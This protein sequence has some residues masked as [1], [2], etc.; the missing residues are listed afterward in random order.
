[1]WQ[2][3]T[4]RFLIVAV[5][6]FGSSRSASAQFGQSQ[7]DRLPFDDRDDE[8]DDDEEDDEDEDDDDDEDVEED[9]DE[10]EFDLA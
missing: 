6:A 5:L 1:M 8:D 2:L 10:T 7:C 4:V 9:E 3:C